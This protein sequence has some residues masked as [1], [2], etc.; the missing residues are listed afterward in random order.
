[1]Q[2]SVYRQS[3]VGMYVGKEQDWKHSESM[4]S[5]S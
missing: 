1:M 4:V 3:T 5:F 2:L